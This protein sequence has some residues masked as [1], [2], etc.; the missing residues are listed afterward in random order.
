MINE[1]Y[2]SENRRYAMEYDELGRVTKRTE[3]SLRSG[4][5]VLNEETFSYDG[6]GNIVESRKNEKTDTYTYDT[7]N[8]S[9]T[10]K[11]E[12]RYGVYIDNGCLGSY[13]LNGEKVDITYDARRRMKQVDGGAYEYW[14]DAENNRVNMYA[15]QT[16]T[17]Y[18]YDCSGGRHRLVW[19][20]DHN[21]KETIYGYG[22]EGLT[23]SLSD[24]EY[25]IYHYDYRGS[26]IAVTDI[27]GNV[28]DTIQYDTYGGV[29]KR[30]GESQLIFGY[31][32]RDGVLT[33][34]NGL[35]YMRAR[36][37]NTDLKRFMSP[38]IIDGSI[39]DSSTLNVYAYVNGNPI[40]YVDPFGLSAERGQG[41]EID[42]DFDPN[43]SDYIGWGMDGQEIS[44]R[45]YNYLKYHFN[46]KKVGNYAII[47]GAHSSAALGQGIR[48][49]RYAFVNASKYPNVFSYVDPITAG[50]EALTISSGGRINWGG[51]L[52]YAVV[53][54]DVGIGIYENIEAGTRTQKIVTDAVV[55]AGVGAGT[56]WLSA[57]AGAGAGSIVPVAGN[58][59]GAVVGT[60][61][62]VVIYV[63][64]DVFQINGKS[65]VE[66]AK[67]GAGWLGDRAVEI[68]SWVGDTAVDVGNWIGDT[69]SDIGGWIG[70]QWDKIW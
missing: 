23:W 43:A 57:V 49:T 61:T 19:T 5:P 34:P 41:I 22:A 54:L 37:Y 30:T 70:D 47:Q 52:N 28:T 60:A 63:V 53:G 7:T 39:A 29:A 15:V 27:E 9:I 11:G 3:Y 58:V 66:W 67:E 18:T 65:P 46:V 38:D 59:V 50:K 26:V 68:G 21:Y 45:T 1:I 48:G 13:M 35:L 6:A 56:I 25:Q 2:P 20:I 55:D 69:A 32:G 36:Y 33:D 16:N 64:T 62:G 24:G 40:S 4:S 8:N 17:K 12:T 51:A 31:N 10:G 44:V 42:W 14:Y